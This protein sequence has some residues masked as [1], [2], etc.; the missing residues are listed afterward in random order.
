M[1]RTLWKPERASERDRRAKGKT[2]Q[3]TSE[4]TGA[5]SPDKLMINW[6]QWYAS[7]GTPQEE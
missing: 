5:L 7:S 3:I 2:L 6:R 1:S 4:V